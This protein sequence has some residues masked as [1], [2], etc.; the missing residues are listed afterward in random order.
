[1]AKKKSA[2]RIVAKKAGKNTAKRTVKKT[3]P[4]NSPAKKAP[5]KKAAAMPVAPKE[6]LS[7]AAAGGPAPTGSCRY[8]DVNNAP[9]CAS[10]VTQAWCSAKGGLWVQDGSC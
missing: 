2:K 6:L 3:I 10:P 4:K 7:A 5:A 1:M 8:F 9:Q